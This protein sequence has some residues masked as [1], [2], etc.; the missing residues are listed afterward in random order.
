MNPV[1]PVIQPAPAMAAAEPAA[2]LRSQFIEIDVAE[3]EASHMQQIYHGIYTVQK[4]LFF[5]SHKPSKCAF[6]HG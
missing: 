4:W 5:R 3:M 6:A 2:A 1:D